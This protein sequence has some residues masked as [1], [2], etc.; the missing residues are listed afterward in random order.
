MFKLTAQPCGLAEV[1][2]EDVAIPAVSQVTLLVLVP[3]LALLHHQCV[4]AAVLFVVVT[5]EE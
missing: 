3:L 4:A 5:A 2:P 1:P